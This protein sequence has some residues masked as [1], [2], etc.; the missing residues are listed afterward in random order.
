MLARLQRSDL[1]RTRMGLRPESSSGPL[2]F[3]V[4][5][6]L[7]CHVRSNVLLHCRLPCIRCRLQIT[8]HL[9]QDR[10]GARVGNRLASRSQWRALSRSRLVPSGIDH[11][12]LMF[13]HFP[14]PEPDSAFKADLNVLR[15]TVS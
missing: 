1:K 15:S 14:F 3:Q 6:L 8:R 12:Y 7:F 2:S 5:V 13:D 10:S 11:A 9:R 4:R